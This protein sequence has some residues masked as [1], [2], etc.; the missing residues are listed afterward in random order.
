MYAG[1][2]CIQ[3]THTGM[4]HGPPLVEAFRERLI[5][6]LASWPNQTLKAHLSSS[7]VMRGS[8]R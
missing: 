8:I 3:Q 7:L 4:G 2:L 6:M 1:S 5:Q